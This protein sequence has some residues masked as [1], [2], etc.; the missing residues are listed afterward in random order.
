VV[1]GGDDAEEARRLL[2]A[3]VLERERRHVQPHV[4]GEQ[5]DD[6]VDVVRWHW[7]F[8]INVPIGVVAALLAALLLRE[9]Y[10]PPARLDL[11]GVALVSAG[12]VSRVWGLVRASSTGWGSAE[13]VA[14]LAAGV[15]LIAGSCNW[16]SRTSEPMVPLRLFR[17][18]VFAAGNATG[19]LMAGSI[20]A[21]G[22]FVT[23]Y[24]SSRSA[25]R[26]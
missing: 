19:F 1:Q 3:V 5:G 12:S 9:S 6:P 11:L 23:Q 18:R 25:T 7:I 17:N 22:F 24:S 10:G 13:I 4:G 16:E 2:D 15:A 26:R 21:A 14:T 8:W 20:L